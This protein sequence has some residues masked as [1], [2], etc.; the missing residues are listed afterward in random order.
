MTGLTSLGIRSRGQPLT[1]VRPS[2]S[3]LIPNLNPQQ[4]SRKVLVEAM[5]FY[6]QNH[7][8]VLEAVL[9]EAR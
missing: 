4:L 8:S 7:P 1:V 9:E 5:F 6:C 3:P 2:R